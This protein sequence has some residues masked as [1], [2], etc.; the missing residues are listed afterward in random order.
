MT[1]LSSRRA[2]KKSKKSSSISPKKSLNPK[3]MKNK[4]FETK[5]KRSSDVSSEKT[6]TDK[7]KPTIVS[8]NAEGNFKSHVSQARSEPMLVMRV[9]PGPLSISAITMTLKRTNVL[10]K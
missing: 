10:R 6:W 8:L 3:K 7:R 9:D 5:S 1:K 2:S 4:T